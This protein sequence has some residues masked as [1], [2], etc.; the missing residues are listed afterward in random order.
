M[1]PMLDMFHMVCVHK[2]Y[3]ILI[4]LILVNNISLGNHAHLS[5]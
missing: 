3:S 2:F 1:H 5:S 4:I